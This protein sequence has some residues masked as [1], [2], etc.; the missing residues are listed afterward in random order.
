MMQEIDDGLNI[1]ERRT[2][3]FSRSDKTNDERNRIVR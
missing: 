2:V 3:S 1:I